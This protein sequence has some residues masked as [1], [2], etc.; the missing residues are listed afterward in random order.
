MVNDLN[1][2]MLYNAAA[3]LKKYDASL[4]VIIKRKVHLKL[5]S[6]NE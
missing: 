2:K 3:D 4:P 5:V 6:K 1:L